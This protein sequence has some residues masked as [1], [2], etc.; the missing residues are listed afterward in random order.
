MKQ[1][2]VLQKN[3]IL[4]KSLV[5]NEIEH[6]LSTWHSTRFF[7]NDAMLRNIIAV[8]KND[9]WFYQSIKVDENGTASTGDVLIP[10]VYDPAHIEQ[11]AAKFRTHIVGDPLIA[12]STNIKYLDQIEK[13]LVSIKFDYIID[14]LNI[15][16]VNQTHKFF[17]HENRFELKHIETVL[18]SIQERQN[19][20]NTSNVL[21]FLRL[22]HS[23]IIEFL[24]F[25]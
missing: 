13:L 23:K 8:L 20:L 24:I 12:N 15:G 22:L 5:N 6:I 4:K 3:S 1:N 7:P 25:C 19:K 16:Y 9:N 21:I 14:G 17:Q 2:S 10:A 11:I 18:D